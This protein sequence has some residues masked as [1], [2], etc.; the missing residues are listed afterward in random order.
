MGVSAIQCPTCGA[1]LARVGGGESIVCRYCG[2]NVEV[3]VASR[4]V[5]LASTPQ[6]GRPALRVAIAAVVLLVVVGV[7]VVAMRPS[8]PPSAPTAAPGDPIPMQTAQATTAATAATAAPSASAAE[9]SLADLALEFGEKGTGPGQLADARAITVDPNGDIYVADYR[10]LRVQRFDGSGKFLATFRLKEGNQEGV[11]KGLAATYDG[12]LWVA[13]DGDLV[14]L[15][16]P[17]GK[18]V[19]TVPNQKPKVSYG[20]IAVDATNTIYVQNYG[21][22]TFIS[23]DGRLPQSDNLRKLDRNGNLVTA[24]KDVGGGFGGFGIAVDDVGTIVLAERGRIDVL[25]AKGKV[26]A[27]FSAGADGGGVALDGKGRIFFSSFRGIGV[28]DTTGRAIGTIG[29]ANVRGLAM[30]KGGRLHAVTNDGRV[31]VYSLR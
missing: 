31:L 7:V 28:C 29:T 25:D 18:V 8:P 26:Q 12:N 6:R 27:R 9:P 23:T 30:G 21:I 15:K 14:E 4:D 1:S 20:A 24:W 11:I 22:G 5:A 13:R 2:T 19:R 17:D 3:A 16:L 10:S